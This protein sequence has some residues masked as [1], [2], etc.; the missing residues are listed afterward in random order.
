MTLAQ[1]IYQ[2]SL[3][4][5]EPAAREALE[6]IEFLEQR[7]SATL[8]AP[9]ALNND[10]E[11]FLAAVTGTLSDDFPNDIFDDDLGLALTTCKSPLLPAPT[12]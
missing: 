12:A 8:M 9:E 2:H 1:T 4:L 10:T 6:F 7:Y 11:A 5:P 3:N